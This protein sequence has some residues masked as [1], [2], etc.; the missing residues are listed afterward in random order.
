MAAICAL[1]MFE[2]RPEST[3]SGHCGSR[4]DDVAVGGLATVRSAMARPKSRTFVWWLDL[5]ASSRSAWKQELQKPNVYPPSKSAGFH[6]GRYE[7]AAPARR[8]LGGISGEGMRLSIQ[9]VAVHRP[10]TRQQRRRR[11]A[12]G[13]VYVARTIATAWSTTTLTSA[14]APPHPGTIS[15][16]QNT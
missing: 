13:L 3:R 9:I 11:Q 8:R 4:A 10:H 12:I 6:P 16:G 14:S 1:E 5:A 2:R 7:S 15:S